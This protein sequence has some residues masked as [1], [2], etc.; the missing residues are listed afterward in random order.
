MENPMVH[1]SRMPVSGIE[2][3]THAWVPVVNGRA[4]ELPNKGGPAFSIADAKFAAATHLG[5]P[6]TSL[7]F[8]IE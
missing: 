2:G 1:I 6:Q 5:V 7:R 4:I 3:R 8:R